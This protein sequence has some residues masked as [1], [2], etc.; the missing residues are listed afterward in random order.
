MKPQID[1]G[2]VLFTAL[3][4]L[5]LLVGGLL[6]KHFWT[7][8]QGTGANADNLSTTIRNVMLMI[9]AFLALPLAIWRGWVAERQVR[10]TNE[11]V[12]AAH[13]AISNQRFQAA[14][15]MLGH[16][17]SAV[18]LGAIHTLAQL[19][20]QD[21]EQ[22]YLPTVRLFES[23][24][25][26]PRSAEQANTAR[27][28]RG[29]GKAVREDVNAVLEYIGSRTQEDLDYEESVGHSIDLQDVN[30][31]RWDVSGMNLARCSLR[32]SYF[33]RAFLQNAN[34]TD[35]D[36]SDCSFGGAHVEGAVFRRAKIAGAN[37]TRWYVND[38]GG[39]SERGRLT[40]DQGPVVG[41]VQAQLDEALDELENPPRL[42]DVTDAETGQQLL[43][44][45]RQPT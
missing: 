16:D 44:H 13:E 7:E 25:R 30:F 14:A 11:S 19:S 34:F 28:A 24:I 18:R 37:F 20:R 5:V 6:A 3:A 45:G 8:L 15:Q 4:L 10:A 27:V 32:E 1:K 17:L 26:R 23:F 42:R 12:S 39:Y 40:A 35:S 29:E 31:D 43:W 9:G 2:T 38:D 33:G 21:R 36:L 22:Y 41:L